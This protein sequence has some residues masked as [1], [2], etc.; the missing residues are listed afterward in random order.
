MYHFT[1][2]H[3][4]LHGESFVERLKPLMYRRKN[5]LRLVLDGMPAHKTKAVKTYVASHPRPL[6][7][8][9]LPGYAPDLNPEELVWRHANRTGYM[10]KPLQPGESLEARVGSQPAEI[11]NNPKVVRSFFKPPSI[12]YISDLYVK[13]R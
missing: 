12:A 5:P 9:M 4:A 8:H 10:H 13:G 6:T 1:R 2:Y 7:L 3:G 11:G